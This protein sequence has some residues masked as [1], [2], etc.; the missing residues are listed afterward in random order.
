MANVSFISQNFR[1]LADYNLLLHYG[2]SQSHQ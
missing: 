2:V 1:T